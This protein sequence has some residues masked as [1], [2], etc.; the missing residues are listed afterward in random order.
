[1]RCSSTG[2]QASG[3]AHSTPRARACDVTRSVISK[4]GKSYFAAGARDTAGD[5]HQQTV[6]RPAVSRD[7]T[8]FQHQ[9]RPHMMLRRAPRAFFI[10]LRRAPRLHDWDDRS[11]AMRALPGRRVSASHRAEAQAC[12]LRLRLCRLSTRRRW[13]ATMS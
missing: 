2:E 3:S 4:I 13:D 7:V 1:M 9:P 12:F 8:Q 6:L 5:E 10:F 11:L